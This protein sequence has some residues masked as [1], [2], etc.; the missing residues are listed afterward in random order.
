MTNGLTF[1]ASAINLLCTTQQKQTSSRRKSVYV[2]CFK[3]FVHSNSELPAQEAATCSCSLCICQFKHEGRKRIIIPLG[4]FQR[5]ASWRYHRSDGQSPASLPSLAQTNLS[6]YQR[7]YYAFER[8][9]ERPQKVCHC[10]T[11]GRDDCPSGGSRTQ[12]PC[13]HT[14]VKAAL[15]TLCTQMPTSRKTKKCG[16][17]LRQVIIKA[18]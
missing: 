14:K 2:R 11:P 9:L 6:Q 12:P 10:Y 3:S 13:A 4:F 18:L 1:N 7:G 17:A 5:I 8:S 16:P 15:C